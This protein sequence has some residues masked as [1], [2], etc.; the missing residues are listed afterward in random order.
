MCS[1]SNAVLVGES[2]ERRDQKD[3]NQRDLE[4]EKPTKPHQLI[5]AKTR[6]RPA[7]P[8]ENENHHGDFSKEN[9]DVDQAKD[10]SVRAVGKSWKMPATEKQCNDD[11]RS[12]DHRGVFAEKIQGEL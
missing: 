12:G 5:P 11:G 1:S 6:Q 7:D 4:K 9:R 8:H 2:Q 3:V 10:P